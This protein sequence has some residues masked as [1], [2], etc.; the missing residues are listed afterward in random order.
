M[1]VGV[2]SS[3]NISGNLNQL[4]T[5]TSKIKPEGRNRHAMCPF[6]IN[7]STSKENGEKNFYSLFLFGGLNEN[8]KILNDCWILNASPGEMSWFKPKLQSSDLPKERYGH[9]CCKFQHKQKELLNVIIFGGFNGFE[10][11]NDIW[12]FKETKEEGIYEWIEVKGIPRFVEE[13]PMCI[14]ENETKPCGRFGHSSSLIHNS[15]L[16]FGGMNQ[17]ERLNDLWSFD[18]LTKRWHKLNWTG[19]PPSPRYD[20]VG[21][22]VSNV[23]TNKEKYMVIF[24]GNTLDRKGYSNEVFTFNL[25]ELLWSN[26]EID[27]TMKG[28]VASSG[29]LYQKDKILIFGGLAKFPKKIKRTNDLWSYDTELEKDKRKRIG[30]Y[31]IDGSRKPLGSGAFATV[32]RALSDDPNDP[33]ECALKLMNLEFDKTKD[34]VVSADILLSEIQVLMKL[35]HPNVL[36]LKDSFLDEDKSHFIIVMPLCDVGSLTEYIKDK[37]NNLTEME[38]L[39]IM[40]QFLN[41]M[42]YI[43]EKKVIHR[44]IK[45]GKPPT[46]H[47]QYFR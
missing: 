13:D 3:E 27:E 8:N 46:S 34:N 7:Y 18:M 40:V 33:Q 17:Y 45:S 37:K 10:Y 19:I 4:E 41:G 2:I 29:A 44:D 30:N 11:F 47:E 38:L 15:M 39:D 1:S 16:I 5:L 14:Y 28:R 35:I 21:I 25:S 12:M 43:H 31:W 36:T 42:A 20:H 32:Y 22:S 9:S 6:K 26:G 24:G 23:D